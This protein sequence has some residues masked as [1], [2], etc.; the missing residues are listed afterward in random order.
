MGAIAAEAY[1]RFQTVSIDRMIVFN[2]VCSQQEIPAW[3]V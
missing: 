2:I 3:R 1:R